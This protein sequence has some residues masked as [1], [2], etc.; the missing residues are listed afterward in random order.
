M[1]IARAL[2]A[3]RRCTTTGGPPPERRGGERRLG[4]G[5]QGE[6]GAQEVQGGDAPLGG[7]DPHVRYAATEIDVQLVGRL[8]GGAVGIGGPRDVVRGD[9]PALGLIGVQQLG[10]RPSRAAPSRASTEVGVVG[11]SGSRPRPAAFI[12]GGSARPCARPK[13]GTVGS[14]GTSR[15][16]GWQKSGSAWVTS[17]WTYQFTR[18]TRSTWTPPDNRTPTGAS[19]T[20]ADPMAA[21]P[22]PGVS[23]RR[24]LARQV[25]SQAKVRR[26]SSTSTMRPTSSTSAPGPPGRA[27][28]AS[29]LTK[30]MSIRSTGVTVDGINVRGFAPSV[31]NMGAI[32]VEPPTAPLGRC[33]ARHVDHR[34]VPRCHRRPAS[35]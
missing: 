25:A 35:S 24:T 1:P 7:G 17:N 34:R 23:P 20:R 27:V 8:A 18:P 2:T 28:R 14:Y 32:T 10:A 4:S 33:S 3:S 19:S 30:A 31:P 11:T 15:V 13:R 5:E 21:H 22:G 9:R 12:S 26:A 29:T 6:P 16:T